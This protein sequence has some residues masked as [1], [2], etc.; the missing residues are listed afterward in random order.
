[1]EKKGKRNCYVC[2]NCGGRIITYNRIDIVTPFMVGCRVSDDCEG[3]MHTCFYPDELQNP[4]T[5]SRFKTTHAW[6]SYSQ[7][8]IESFRSEGREEMVEWAE[9]YGKLVEM[10]KG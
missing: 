3:M 5:W 4:L 10:K 1:V 7:E 2:Q 9:N 8:E 6:E